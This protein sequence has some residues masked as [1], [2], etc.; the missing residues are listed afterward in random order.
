MKRNFKSEEFIELKENAF[1]LMK[2]AGYPVT[3]VAV[4]LDENLPYMGHTTEVDGLPLVVVSGMAVARG[5]ALNLLIHELGHVYR[6]QSNHP[7]HDEQLNLSIIAWVMHGKAV[8]DYQED[9][10]HAIINHLQDLYSDDIFF[11]IFDKDMADEN[12]NEFFLGWV[13]KPIKIVKNRKQSWTNTGYMLSAAFAQANLYRHNIEDVNGLLE[14]AIKDFLSKIDKRISEKY[15]FFK[16]FM[17]NLPEKVT[18]KE[19]EKLLI[20]YLSE[21]LKIANA[22]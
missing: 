3:N 17:I 9:A 21:F 1:F 22:I 2:K 6:N 20:K 7:S 11:K 10:I 16:N 18:E 5:M 15:D 4:V 19:Y 14:N 12:I 13:H 8:Q